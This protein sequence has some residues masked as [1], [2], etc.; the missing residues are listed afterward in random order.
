MISIIL[1][2]IGLISAVLVWSLYANATIDVY[3]Y[4]DKGRLLT[5]TKDGHSIDRYLY[6]VTGKAVE[7][8]R[9]VVPRSNADNPFLSLEIEDNRTE[10]AFSELGDPSLTHSNLQVTV[11]KTPRVGIGEFIVIYVTS[12]IGKSYFY[13]KIATDH[14]TNGETALNIPTS[15]LKDLS[16]QY[17]AGEYR[18]NFWIVS[19]AGAATLYEDELIFSLYAD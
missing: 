6:D 15:K 17:L 11:L 12:P 10:I 19:D 5:I 14:F 13:Q 3:E 9:N 1:S 2:K 16:G 8:D 7:L 4:D 18:I